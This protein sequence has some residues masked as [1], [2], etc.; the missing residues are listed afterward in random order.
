MKDV[1]TM[2]QIEENMKV[3]TTQPRRHLEKLYTQWQDTLEEKLSA[4]E[5]GSA[6]E[7]KKSVLDTMRDKIGQL[8]RKARK[9]WITQKMIK[10]WMNEG[11]RRV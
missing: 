5:C 8:D 10:K 1:Q 7:L 9:P 11:K 2:H 3:Q 4:T 6:V